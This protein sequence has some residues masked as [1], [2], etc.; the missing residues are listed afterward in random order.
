MYNVNEL[1]VQSLK[2]RLDE[3]EKVR[4]VDVRSAE[5][6][7]Q[8]IIAGGE[9]LPLHTLPTRLDAFSVGETIVFY[10]RSGQR[11]AQACAFLKENT[12]IEA[13]NLRGGIIAW[14]QAGYEIV[15]PQ[16]DGT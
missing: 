1:D 12:G 13:I 2:A 3:G 14:Y 9:F 11:S 6:Y 8:G 7:Q 16:A 10:C 4:L 15:A 5:E